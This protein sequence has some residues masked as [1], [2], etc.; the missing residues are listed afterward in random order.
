MQGRHLFLIGYD[1]SCP[2]RLR[3]AL[4]L[5]R[6]HALGGQKSFYECWLSTAELQR[7]M[8]SLR[9]LIDLDTD[10]VIF[11]RLDARCQPLLAGN[12]QPINQGDFFLV[13]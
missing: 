5:V 3:Q 13:Q 9:D 7:A 11:I 10:R 1:I 2:R 12:A 4:T 6:A 8:Q